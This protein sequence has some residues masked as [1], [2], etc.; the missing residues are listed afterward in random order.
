[1]GCNI[2]KYS[3]KGVLYVLLI[4]VFLIYA[5]PIAWIVLTSFNHDV[6]SMA[7]PPRLFQ[8]FTIDNYIKAFGGRGL[9][10]NFRNSLLISSV[11]SVLALV[12]GTPAAYALSRFRFKLN[13]PIYMGF[14]LARVAPAMIIAIPIFVWSRALAVF[15]TVGL[16][17]FVN[18]SMNLAWVV[19][20]MR[21]FFD[22]VPL[23][24]DEA[25]LIDGCNKLSC[26]IRIIIPLSMPGLCSTMIFCVI[27]SW[28]EYFFTLVLTSVR[29]QNL[30]AA[31]TTFTSVYGM[32]WGQMC[33]A[34][35]VIM[36]PV[37]IFVMFMQKYLIKGF[38]MGSVK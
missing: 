20:M 23:Q 3:I 7:I 25:A 16:M 9:R 19:W 29:A 27:T 5:I 17:I 15:D 13:T 14:M 37:L 30:P 10:L 6:N 21:V 28:N 33:A 11:S 18:S 35:T 24:V 26:L 31:L 1:M 12:I 2:K 36:A 34:A 8:D 32:N 22:D 38:T 4:L